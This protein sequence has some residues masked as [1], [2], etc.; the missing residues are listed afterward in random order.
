MDVSADK[1]RIIEPQIEI[2]PSGLMDI[3]NAAMYLGIS[4]RTLRK[5]KD[6]RMVAFVKLGGLLKFRQRDLDA[7]IEQ[8]MEKA[9]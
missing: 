1:T 5:W 9:L 6:R 8:N 7:W 4:V 2:S 3:A